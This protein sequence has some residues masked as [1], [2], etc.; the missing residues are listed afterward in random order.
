MS[1][2][3]DSDVTWV[4]HERKHP[5]L[6]SKV[7][8]EALRMNGPTPEIGNSEKTNKRR[9]LFTEGVPLP[10]LD[11]S[12]GRSSPDPLDG[13]PQS[14]VQFP[15]SSY[16]TPERSGNTGQSNGGGISQSTPQNGRRPGI[17]QRAS[18]ASP[19]PRLD[20]DE[21]ATRSRRNSLP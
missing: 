5:E 7:A 16:L 20:A 12:G 18:T 3:N 19:P 13:S 15:D 17:F 6:W 8:G 11:F 1:F 21:S 4:I 2:V 9:V 14:D 10:V